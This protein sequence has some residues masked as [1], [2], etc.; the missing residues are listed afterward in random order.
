MRTLFRK[1]LLSVALVLLAA[2][3][4]ACQPQVVEVPV[5][6]EV[7]RIVTET[8]TVVEEVQVEVEVTRADGTS[9]AFTAR[10]RIDTANELEYYRNGGILQYV[11]RDLAAD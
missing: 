2:V 1:L 7:T 5:E 4:I 10:C 8:E 11:L 3:A 6:V 9:F